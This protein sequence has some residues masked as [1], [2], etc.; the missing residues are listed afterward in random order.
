MTSQR[1]VADELTHLTGRGKS[2]DDAYADLVS[3]LSSGTLRHSAE[4][5]PHGTFTDN[6]PGGAVAWNPDADLMAGEMYMADVVCFCDIPVADLAI[7]AGKYSRF[8]LAFRKTFLLAK[9]ATP[10]FYVARDAGHWEGGPLEDHFRAE[11]R[12][13]HR[14]FRRVREA[15]LPQPGAKQEGLTEEEADDELFLLSSRVMSFLA[16]RVFAF[17]KPFEALLPLD[18]E[19]NYYMEREWRVIGNVSFSLDDVHR[20]LLPESY[21]AR[22]REDVPDYQRQVSFLDLS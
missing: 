4:A 2:P 10:V 13:F 1:Y 20:V 21:S 7:H 16:T 5:T 6:P 12:R 18:D 8:G 14:F 11:M 22:L 19:H 9:G 17:V 15:N 3:I